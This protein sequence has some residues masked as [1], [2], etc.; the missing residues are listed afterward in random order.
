MQRIVAMGEQRRQL[1]AL[2]DCFRAALLE[3]RL[4]TAGSTNIVPVVI[5]SA[6]HTVAGAGYLRE[7]GFLVLPV[8]PPTVPQG[9]SRFRLSLTAELHWQQIESLPGLI[10][11]WLAGSRTS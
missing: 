9:T 1:K 11:D 6:E 7:Q 3:R 4:P 2:S 10:G 5:G 8:R